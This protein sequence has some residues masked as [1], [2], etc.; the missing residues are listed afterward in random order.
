MNLKNIEDFYP[1]SPMQ[2]GMLFHSLA[3]PNSG[4]YFE[5]FS[6]TLKGELNLAAFNYAWQQV[7]NRYSILRT[8]FVWEGLKEPVQIVHRQVK[9]SCTTKDWRHLSVKQQE[10]EIEA[11]LERDCLCDFELTRPPLM[12]LTLIQLA[13]NFYHFVWS[14]HHLLLDGWSVPIIFQE[15]FAYYQAF[16][17]GEQLELVTP[18]PYRDYIVWLQQQDLS[19]AETFWRQTLQ[20]FTTPTQLWVDRGKLHP[21]DKEINRDI[22]TEANFNLKN[23]YG[24]QEISLNAST[25]AALQSFSQ[26]H[27]LTLNTII[28]G[29]WALLLSRYSNEKDLVFGA[30]ISGRPP[31]LAEAESMVGLF[32]NTLPVRVKIDSETLLLPWLKEIQTRQI[33]ARQYEYSSLTQIQGWSEVTRNLPLFESIIVFENYPVTEIPLSETDFNL[34]IQFSH[35]FDRTNYP[36]TLGVTPGKELLLEIA[37]EK[38]D[39]RK[40]ALRDRFND[41]TITRMLGHLSTLLESIAVNP[42]QK[43]SELSL[44]TAAEKQQLLFEWNNTY[45]E[46]PTDKCIHTLFE[47]QVVKKPNAIAIVFENQQL[48]YQEL[49]NKAN[50]LAGYLRHSS[51]STNERE[52]GLI[53][54]CLNRSLEM[55]VAILGILKAGFAYLP[56]D[57]SLPRDRVTDILSDAHIS[58]LLT[59]SHLINKFSSVETICLD[60]DWQLI[61][62]QSEQN[63]TSEVTSN[64]LAYVIYTSGSTGKP[65]GVMVEHSSLVN[66][67]F[68]WEDVYQLNSLRTHL[69]MAN[70][71]FDVFTGDLVRAL[72]SG[73]KLVLCP[74]DLLLD[75]KGLYALIKQYQIDCGEFVP[76]VLR[77]LMEYLEKTNQQL[78]MSLVICGS[79]SW[80]GGEYQK[81]QQFLGKQTRLI[82]SFGVTE[83]TID[84][85]YFEAKTSQLLSKQSKQLVP[86]GKPFANTQL[87][88]LD[89]DLQ[90]VPIGVAGELYIGGAG[91]A[92]GYLN[93]PELTQEKFISIPPRGD[94]LYKTGDLAKYLPDGNLEFLGRIDNQV[95][96]R[97][98]RLELG[99]IEAV[100][101]GYLAIKDGVVIVSEDKPGDKKLVAYFVA[102]EPVTVKQLREFLKSKLPDYMIPA[103]W[104]ELEV[105]PVTPNGKIDRKSLTKIK[106]SQFTTE[107]Q[108]LSYHTPVTEL[109]AGIWAEVLDLEGVEIND[110]FFD[111]GGHSLIA[112]RLISRVKQVFKIELPL[113]SLFENPT[114]VGLAECIQTN[115]NPS[116]QQDIK[117]I[118]RTE[119]LPLS[120][121]QQRLWFLAQ[122]EPDSCDYNL[123]AAFTLQGKLNVTA[124]QESFNEIIKRHEIL[125]TSLIEVEGEARQVITPSLAVNLEVIELTDNRQVRQLIKEEALQPFD[126]NKIPLFRI[127]LLRCNQ[128]KHIL[129]VVMHHI[130]SDFWSEDILLQEITTLYEAKIAQ[131]NVTLPELPIQYAD[132]AVWQRQYLQAEVLDSHLEYWQKQL[133]GDLPVLKFN[134]Q[135]SQSNHGAIYDFA[136]EEKL[137]KEI[138]ALSQRENTTL[139]ITLLTAFKVLLSIYTQEKDLIIGTPVANRD[140][141]ELEELIGFFVNTLLLRTNLSGN[142]TFR[143]LLG[144]VR[145]VTLNGYAHQALPFEKLVEVLQP[146][147]QQQELPFLQV[148][149]TL[150]NKDVKEFKLPNLAIDEIELDTEI[151]RYQLRL[152]LAE[153]STGLQGSFGYKTDLFE[154][155][156]ITFMA[157]NLE[158]IL[159]Q[160]ITKPD[161]SLTDLTAII[162]RVQ[163][164][165]KNIQQKEL[166]RTSLS[167]LKSIKRKIVK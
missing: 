66:A 146:N 91:V 36:L 56:V 164:E 159:R 44:L 46:Y 71:A 1:L 16:T 45:V 38:S 52:E 118:S 158:T 154:A 113:R 3:A 105:L 107:S 15:V 41:D 26:K 130:I 37:Y 144:R 89:S 114:L 24:C 79:D 48:T 117:P 141:I 143:E 98:F 10:K 60:T 97:G 9:I 96:I 28:Q 123:P 30:T 31:T 85:C 129:I 61:T 125:R 165:Q 12:R 2:Q 100:L 137:S 84:S 87:Y 65:K 69:Q 53:G 120:F 163:E 39:Q 167:K 76:I 21:T 80:Y 67:Y 74:Q 93:N 35:S 5:Q 70:F 160:V 92:R 86:I 27:Q 20:G 42:Q 106:R 150:T 131:K 152:D 43:L 166:A 104:V 162:N 155:D 81:F 135:L 11:F 122:L 77:N 111:L 58:L 142:L 23:D 82:N 64:N 57:S 50:Q 32:I 59:Q 78:D 4:V 40:L 51:S 29:A 109:L 161:I 148:W 55:I 90:P 7:M 94:L 33:E 140:R 136:F 95:K 72:C 128:E 49:N 103:V 124:L 54:I 25:T 17:R 99:E 115:L 62:Q 102:K 138:I 139:F 8:G 127:K 73:G 151:E 47:E 149:F 134:S 88:I 110:N 22:G 108:S 6:C 14:H 18:R 34:E 19:E 68:A 133:S 153:S 13:D 126:L 156:T 75:A 63:S 116:F 121:A 83:A 119:K 101:T 132:F 145:E 157:R 147:R 112:T